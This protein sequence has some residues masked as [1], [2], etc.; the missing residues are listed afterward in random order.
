MK[1]LLIYFKKYTLESILAPVFK[2]FEAILELLIPLIVAQIINKGIA[3]GDKFY[4]IQMTLL[5][6][7]CGVVGLSFSIA[8]QFFSA[9]ASVGFSTKVRLELFKK[10][11]SLTFSDIDNLGTSSMITRLTYDVTQ[12]QTGINLTLRLLLRSPFVVFGAAIMASILLPQNAYI[13]WVAILVLSIV[14][15]CILLISMPMHKKVQ[16][17]LD[18]VLNKTKE[19]LSGVRVIRAFGAEDDEITSYNK[20]TKKLEKS[21]NKVSNISNLM[22][23]LTYVIVNLSICLIIYLGGK[24][25]FEGIILQGTLIAI[26]NYMTQILV[27]LIKLANLIITVSKA[28]A[29][30]KRIAYILNMDTVIKIKESKR[31]ENVPYIYFDHVFLKYEN[32]SLPT[33]SDI[34]F[35]VNRGETIGIIGGTGSGKSSV[36]NLLSR[37]YDPT[38]GT[39]YLNGYDIMSYNPSD[40]RNDVGF[41]LQKSV[42]FK[43]TIRDNIK[44]GNANATDEE[45]IEALKCAQAMDV[46]NKKSHKLDEIVEQGGRNFSGGERQRLAIAR[47]LVKKPKILILDDSS[48]ALDYATDKALRESIASLDY[49]P[50][51][52]IVTQRTSSIQN[53]TN[54]IVLDDGK[55]VGFGSHD[56]LLQNCELYQEIYYSQFKKEDSDE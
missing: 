23:P 28:I 37:F 33:L 46:V 31:N 26:Y 11:Q 20:E 35:S 29:S 45:I 16:N 15:F 39:I 38:D 13:F 54:I 9:K 21:Q 56:Y 3:N 14:I 19:N 43:G 53:A 5:M 50:T 30:S 44:W 49:K 4:I 55:I 52:F 7:L 47:A 42:L 17:N 36:V 6:V 2:L 18:N 22:N 48:S 41:V 24:K 10:I 8:G 51:T 25:V 27:E 40:L 32:T 12:V 34:T 1:K